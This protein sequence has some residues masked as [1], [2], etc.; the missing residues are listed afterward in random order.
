MKVISRKRGYTLIEVVIYLALS[1]LITTLLFEIFFSINNIFLKCLNRS[2][3]LNSIENTFI[4][5]YDISRDP[6]VVKME[7]KNESLKIYYSTEI[8]NNYEVKHIK[9]NDKD[10]VVEYYQYKNGV[11]ITSE[12]RSEKLMLNIDDFKVYK[13]KNVIYIK[14][15][16]DSDEYIKSI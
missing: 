12:R 13:K 1:I 7:K 10:L 4:S 11:D 14:V 5:I 15:I 8:N 16:K 3:N 6:R 2:N 9:K